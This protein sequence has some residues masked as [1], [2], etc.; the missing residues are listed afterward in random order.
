M[1]VKEPRIPRPWTRLTDIAN[2]DLAFPLRLQEIAVRLELFHVDELGVVADRAVGR[3][4]DIVEYIL[5]VWVGILMLLQIPLRRVG[6][7]RQDQRRLDWIER[8]GDVKLLVIGIRPGAGN[9]GDEFFR[10]PF[11]QQTRS[12]L[13]SSS[14]DRDNFDLRKFFL[15]VRKIAS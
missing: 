1:I 9:I 4:A 7:F 15:E 6:D 2:R 13:V 14:R 10:A 3:R 11:R 12:E 8:L 5:S